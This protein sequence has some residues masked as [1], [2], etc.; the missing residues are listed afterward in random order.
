MA[1]SK[2][3]ALGMVGESHPQAALEAATHGLINQVAE[4]WWQT[5]VPAWNNNPVRRDPRKIRVNLVYK[6]F[7]NTPQP[8]AC[9][10][11]SR[12]GQVLSR[13]L[14]MQNFSPIRYPLQAVHH[15][16]Y[17][18]FSCLL[19]SRFSIYSFISTVIGQ[20]REYNILCYQENHKVIF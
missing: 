11:R 2:P 9:P 3:K 17:L 16:F 7:S 14:C 20:F 8:K 15:S 4:S 10:E 5:C 1:A 19:Y 12:M 18:V 13:E 6:A